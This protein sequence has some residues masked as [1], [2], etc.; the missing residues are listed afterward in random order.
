MSIELIEKYNEAYR[1]GEVLVSDAEYDALCEE[2]NYEPGVGAEISTGDKVTLPIPMGSLNKVKSLEDLIKWSAPH[3]NET[4]AATP[5][6][7][8]CSVLLKAVGRT[9]K[10]VYTRGDGKEGRNILP[11][12]DNHKQIQ[13][14]N[15]MM[16]MANPEERYI[17]SMDEF[18]IIGEIII[19]EDLFKSKYSSTMKNSRNMVAGLINRSEAQAPIHDCM[20][21]LFDIK[22][23]T[24]QAYLNKTNKI[25]ILNFWNH[26]YIQ[27][28][29]L[30]SC[31]A[32]HHMED[33]MMKMWQN[34]DTKVKCDGIVVEFN[35]SLLRDELGLET[36]K[37]NP[38]FA[39]A[40][41]PPVEEQK[42]TTV[43]KIDWRV[44]KD[45]KCIPVINLVPI[46]LDGVTISNVTAHNA[47]FVQD[48]EIRVGSL[49][50]IK[51]SGGVI[52]TIV[53]VTNNDDV[54]EF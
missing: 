49:I 18:Y 6:Y 32:D 4:L 37:L 41:K 13:A 40:F 39:R 24:K 35:S 42:T 22:G 47:S 46:D 31:V 36:G 5:K 14:L 23:D 38:A 45:G 15:E 1:N 29:I 50:T 2:F 25:E 10:A 52:P 11:L 54:T 28:P 48:N 7:D 16:Q 51:R 3:P 17:P 27:T 8:G 44:S 26:E 34:M 9:I 43:D 21:M 33:K 53:K 19:P 30:V 12:L 20:I